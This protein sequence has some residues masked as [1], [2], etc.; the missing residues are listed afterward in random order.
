MQEPASETTTMSSPDESKPAPS[1]GQ[2]IAVN[3]TNDDLQAGLV[4][5]L[6]EEEELK[7]E[8][9]LLQ[10]KMAD[11]SRRTNDARNRTLEARKSIRAAGGAEFDSL[12]YVG[13]DSLSHVQSFW[14]SN[15]WVDA[16]A[17]AK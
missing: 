6:K 8:F 17:L 1:K 4:A 12:L 14:I 7:E 13:G 11:N 2:K 16:N 15:H 9:E 5:A 10:Q 3:P